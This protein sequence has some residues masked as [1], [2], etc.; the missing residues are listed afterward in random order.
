MLTRVPIA[1]IY[2]LLCYA[3]NRLDEKDLVD[4]GSLEQTDTANLFA[5]LLCA[6][7][8][9]ALRRGLNRSYHTRQEEIVGIRGRL[10]VASSLRSPA[11]ELGRTFCE[12]DELDFNTLPN[13][14]IKA[15]LLRL[16]G[17]SALTEANIAELNHLIRELDEIRPINLRAAH[18]Q[19][20][21]LERSNAHYGMLLCICELAYDQLLASE[22]DGGSRKLRGFLEDH[23]KMAALYEDFV[24]NFYALHAPALGYR[25]EGSIKI[26]WDASDCSVGAEALLPEMRTDITLVGASRRLILD[27]KFYHETLSGYFGSERLKSGNLYQMYAYVKNQSRKPGWETCEGL[28]LYPAI[29]ETVEASFTLDGNR[30]HAATVDLNQS[31]QSIHERLVSLIC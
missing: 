19:R 7:V 3:W 6:G 23:Q 20:L 15:T 21:H 1:N 24:R 9:R 18:F 22:D 12:I 13:Q 30:L 10:L 8:R 5:Q 2:Y 4:A 27:C 28:L 25:A 16:A 11:F 17:C 26:G 14:I 31:W 29:D